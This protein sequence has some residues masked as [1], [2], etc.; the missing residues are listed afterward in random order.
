M[1]ENVFSFGPGFTSEMEDMPNEGITAALIDG[2]NRPIF[3]DNRRLIFSETIEQ[4]LQAMQYFRKLLSVENDP[5]IDDVIGAGLVPRFVQFLENDSQR[6]LQ[7][8]AA[9]ALTNIVSGEDRY[10][11]TLVEH[12]VIPIF[13]RLIRTGDPRIVEQSAWGI[14]NM[15]GENPEIRDLCLAEGVMPPLVEAITGHVPT[16]VGMVRNATWTVSNL[17]RG[18]PKPSLALVS[19]AIPVLVRLIRAAN[20]VSIITDACWA[21]SYIADIS[22]EAVDMILATG[23]A[24]HLVSLLNGSTPLI[25]KT[26]ALRTVGNILSG[27]EGQTQRMIDAGVIPALSELL[28][29]DRKAIRREACWALSNIAGG[30]SQQVQ[31]L[32]DATPPVF[33]KI[34]ELLRTGTMDV[35]K[36]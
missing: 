35:R 30:S 25:K 29:M 28:E 23:I 31:A 21:L 5:P 8:E 10:A 11:T 12:G 4:Q 9:W 16:H 15:A 13:V 19:P 24:S 7:F 36:E 6:E 20:D 26:A 18:K 17:C 3:D 32:F 14:G 1:S 33:P 34:A 27:N 2:P 22:E